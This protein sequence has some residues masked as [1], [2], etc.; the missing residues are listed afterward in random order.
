MR[1]L[2]QDRFIPTSVTLA[3]A[4]LVG[5]AMATPRPALAGD[6]PPPV[7]ADKTFHPPVK[8]EA[9]GALADGMAS[10]PPGY[11]YYAMVKVEGLKDRDGNLRV[12]VYP[13]NDRD[14]LVNRMGR[15]EVPTPGGEPQLCVQ[16]PGKGRYAIV[17]HQ[18]R[19]AD[20]SFDVFTDGFGFSNNPKLGFSKPDVS[21]VAFDTTGKV[22]HLTV[23][24]HYI[25][26][27]N[28]NRRH[29]GRR[30]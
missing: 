6:L 1:M 29:G 17:V 12:E 30:H 16:L 25:F 9:S 21:K 18:D 19:D 5:L 26:S 28:R 10:C 7:K 11:K 23:D 27:S 24:M 15:T 4:L 14:F 8:G 3:T 20:N 2:A 22:T 13:D